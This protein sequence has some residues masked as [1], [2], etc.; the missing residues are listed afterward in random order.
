MEKQASN[1]F[2]KKRPNLTH[3]FSNWKK[4]FGLEYATVFV[5]LL[6]L[7]VFARDGKAQ[8]HPDIAP[9]QVQDGIIHNLEENKSSGVKFVVPVGTPV[10]ATASGSSRVCQIQIA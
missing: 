8:G 5:L 3:S 1:K 4:H 10:L 7:S 9:F 2:K 6:F